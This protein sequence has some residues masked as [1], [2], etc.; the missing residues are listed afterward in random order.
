M[1]IHS[2]MWYWSL[3]SSKIYWHE[4]PAPPPL[5]VMLIVESPT[6][7]ASEPGVSIQLNIYHSAVCHWL[8][9]SIKSSTTEPFWRKN[10]RLPFHEGLQQLFK[11]QSGIIVCHQMSTPI[12]LLH[13]TIFCFAQGF[14]LHMC[15]IL[16]LICNLAS[17]S[18]SSSAFWLSWL[19]ACKA[20]KQLSL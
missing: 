12:V 5:L 11:V 14:L 9:P 3:L 1:S 20:G 15:T 7:Q 13:N 6:K 19:H 18:G 17:F 4:C 2:Y 16:T 8:S 10:K